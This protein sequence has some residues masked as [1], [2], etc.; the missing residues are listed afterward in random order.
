MRW[1]RGSLWALA[2]GLAFAVA[3]SGAL[4]CAKGG[5]YYKLSAPPSPEAAAGGGYYDQDTRSDDFKKY[6]EMEEEPAPPP[7]PPPPPAMDMP[8]STTAPARPAPAPAPTPSQPAK[9]APARMVHYD[10]WASLRVGDPRDS[11]DDVVA[12]ATAAGGRTEFVR[13]TV[14]AVRVPVARFDDVWKQILGVGD[15]ID[16]RVTASDV[17]EQFTAIDL[18]A[19]TLREMQKRLVDLLG[20]AKDEQEKLR[21]LQE[22]T[23]VSE[24][25]DAIE[26]QLR[27]LADLA[28]MSRITIELVA[29][30]AFANSGSQAE[31]S[32]FEWIRA[33]SPF[34]RSVWDDNKRVALDVPTDLVS[35]GDRGPFVAESADGTVIWTQRVRNDPVGQAEFWVGAIEE[36]IASEFDTPERRRVGGWDC[37]SVREPGGDPPYRWEVCVAPKGAWLE[38][39]Q[40]FYPNPDQND[41]YAP[42]VDASLAAHGGGA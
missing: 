31:L 35:L 32:G 37:L 24:E 9:P 10:G 23:R 11:V 41:R 8:M 19:K 27:T 14:V 21:L 7:P 26:S 29:R 38:V 30:E 40:A 18:R 1:T 12:I 39:F 3:A 13:G 16:R 5:N 34:R 4:G 42:S 28:A 22:L 2:L 6:K 33:L 36:R 17:T 25:L 15:V 20:R